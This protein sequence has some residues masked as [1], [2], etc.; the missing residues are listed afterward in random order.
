MLN[1]TTPSSERR[2]EQARSYSITPEMEHA[3]PVEQQKQSL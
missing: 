2:P 3:T 1:D